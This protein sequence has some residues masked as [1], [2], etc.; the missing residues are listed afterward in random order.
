MT[1]ELNWH[2]GDDQESIFWHPEA[3]PLPIAAPRWAPIVQAA[4]SEDA[5][6][7][8]R[9]LL[10]G[11]AIGVVVGLLAL[12][13]LLLWRANQGNQLARQDLTAA[14]V[15]LLEAQAAGDVQRYAQLLDPSDAV[16]KARQVAGL[17]HSDQRLPVALTVERV[18]LLGD[19]AEAEVV[20]ANGDGLSRLIYFRLAEG[21]WRLA[22][23]TPGAFGEE[24]QAETT[25]FRI[26]YRERDQRFLPALIDLAEG[27][28][29]ALCGELRCPAD[30]RLLD[31]RLAY[32]ALADDPLATPGAVIVASPGLAG[33]Q[34]N[35]QPGV[36]FNQRLAGQIAMQLAALKAPRASDSLLELIG[37]WAMEEPANGRGPMDDALASMDPIQGLLSLDRAWAAV[38]RRNSNDWL[39]RAEIG[40]VLRFVQSTWGS[41]AVGLLLENA[42][43]SFGEMTRRAFQ[44]D[45]PAFQQLWLA[46][47]AQQETPPPGTSTG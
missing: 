1:V 46:W 44:V 47:L 15:L 11:A 18:R 40:S 3:E 4:T 27:T 36:L 16:W 20:G 35:G 22:P 45:G 8:L 23:P 21:Q 13:A 32:D 12:G 14:T 24:K 42:S 28:Y 17:R 10:L 34:P 19:L 41:D 43:G 31:L 9:L 33:W 38:V 5:P 25:H 7:R 2:E 26:I 30:N 39:A 6:S 37:A 29:V